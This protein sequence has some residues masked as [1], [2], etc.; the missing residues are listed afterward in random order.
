MAKY[1]L[2][3]NGRPNT[4]NEVTWAKGI[5]ENSKANDLESIDNFCMSFNNVEEIKLH[6]VNVAKIQYN[7]G[8]INNIPDFKNDLNI[9]YINN[10]AIRTLS[11]G[12]P[13]TKDKKYFNYE[14]YLQN[15]IISLRHDPLFLS[16]LSARFN[17]S[18]FQ[19]KNM[20]L[21]NRMSYVFKSTRKINN[22]DDYELIKTID[23]FMKKQILKYDSKTREY[24]RDDRGN[25]LY[26]YRGLHDIAMF[27]K[28]YQ[29]R[30][31]PKEPK[32]VGPILTKELPKGQIPGQFSLFDK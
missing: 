32:I 31:L 15:K 20:A 17:G 5:F 11:Y 24:K 3:L 6:L 9:R 4:L 26:S 29:D 21:F 14:D 13:F 1:Y 23:N 8:I 22:G 18:P 10:K 7:E 2:T 16:R 19:S 12:I 30:P 28:N 25:L 27:V